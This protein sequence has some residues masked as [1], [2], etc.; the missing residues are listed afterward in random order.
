MPDRLTEAEI[1]AIVA[2]TVKQTLLTL[3]LDCSDPMETQRDFQWLR[4]WRKSVDSMRGYGARTA[5]SI[6]VAGIIGAVWYAITH[7]G[8]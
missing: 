3:G 6:I 4:D 1:E 7:G 2:R 8:K 5:V